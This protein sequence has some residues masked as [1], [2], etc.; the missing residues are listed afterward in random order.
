[1][2]SLGNEILHSLTSQ[3]KYEMRI[4]LIDFE[5][6]TAFAKY[7]EFTIGDESSKFKILANGYYGTAGM[8]FRYLDL[9]K[10]YGYT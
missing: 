1:M 8:D 7:K 5:G 6:N 3:G 2:L 9:V 10:S 4:D